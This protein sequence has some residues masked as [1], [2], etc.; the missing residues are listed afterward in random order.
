MSRKFMGNVVQNFVEHKR[1]GNC[2]QP[3]IKRKS[4]AKITAH[5]H[6]AKESSSLQHA[7][8]IMQG[9][10]SQVGSDEQLGSQNLGL[11]DQKHL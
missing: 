2:F 1:A 8:L 6:T 9:F 11:P 4:K 3:E 5:N 10:S 7:G